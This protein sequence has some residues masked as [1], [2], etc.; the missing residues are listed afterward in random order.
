MGM[1]NKEVAEINGEDIGQFLDVDAEENGS[2]TGR[3]LRLKVRIDIRQPLWR[4]FTIEIEGEEEEKRWCPIKYEFLAEVCY[5][6][7]IIGHTDKVCAVGTTASEIHQ[8]SKKLGVLPPQRR[9]FEEIKAKQ[10]DGRSKDVSFSRS[11]GDWRRN[12]EDRLLLGR[13]GVN[14]VGTLKGERINSTEMMGVGVSKPR[15]RR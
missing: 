12:K 10:F 15:C 7:G 2:T 9:V 11:N 4:G 5:S 6:C 3:Y 8:Y 13:S 14:H 1:M